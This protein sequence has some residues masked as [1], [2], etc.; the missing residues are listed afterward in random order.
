MTAFGWRAE[1]A[2]FELSP[3]WVVLFAAVRSANGPAIPL[4]GIS[5]ARPNLG[6]MPTVA[7][8]AIAELISKVRG[9]GSTSLP[10]LSGQPQ[11]PPIGKYQKLGLKRGADMGVG[12]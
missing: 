10:P 7:D 9:R 2:L 5:D 12:C 11:I 4:L 3:I 1:G 8:H 6:R